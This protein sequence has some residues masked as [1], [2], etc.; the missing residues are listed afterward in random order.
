MTE[1]V[2]RDENAVETIEQPT[3]V[4]PP[5]LT[6]EDVRD[7]VAA[8]RHGREDDES[9]HSMED[10]LHLAVLRH[11][12]AGGPNAAELAAEAIKTFD[13]DFARWCA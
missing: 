3:R 5:V 1:L 2:R 4:R 12:A 10:S 13:L 8:I 6:V 9:A 11:I 7:A